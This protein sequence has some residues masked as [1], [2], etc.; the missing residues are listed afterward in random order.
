MWS[1]LLA[2]AFLLAGCGYEPSGRFEPSAPQAHTEPL[3]PEN[4]RALGHR[5]VVVY[6][7]AA[8]TPE[9]SSALAITLTDGQSYSIQL[10]GEWSGERIVLELDDRTK[11]VW[12]DAKPGETLFLRQ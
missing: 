5:K 7:P 6:Q 11:E 2:A 8:K 9:P 4:Y 10:P 12:L 1:R 3:P